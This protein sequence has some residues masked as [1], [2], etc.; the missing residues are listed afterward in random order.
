MT[1]TTIA[2]TAATIATISADYSKSVAR[3][4][5][6]SLI[7]LTHSKEFRN[8]YGPFAKAKNKKA[9][10]NTAIERLED[11]IVTGKVPVEFRTIK[12]LNK[13][14]SIVEKAM[15]ESVSGMIKLPK[16]EQQAKER[17]L[18]CKGWRYRTQSR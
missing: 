17:E 12:G 5:V 9:F 4:S 18:I 8:A 7:K 10:M 1:N 6:E 11:L 15:K 16:T 2:T 13:S 14:I 3:M